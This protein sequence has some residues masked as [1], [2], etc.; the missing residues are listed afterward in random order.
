MKH[1][2]A[3]SVQDW[4]LCWKEHSIAEHLSL[5]NFPMNLLAYLHVD[6]GMVKWE[7]KLN[8]SSMLYLLQMQFLEGLV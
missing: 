8:M 2:S 1:N 7:R 6:R 5:F 3:A 4:E